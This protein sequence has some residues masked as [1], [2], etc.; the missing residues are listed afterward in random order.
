M[1]PEKWLE[2]WWFIVVQERRPYIER[3]PTKL[4]MSVSGGQSSFQKLPLDGD[5]W[6]FVSAVTS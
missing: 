4:S 6:R 1:A 3:L 2:P 5:G